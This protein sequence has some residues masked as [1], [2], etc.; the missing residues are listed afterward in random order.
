MFIKSERSS[1]LRARIW[2]VVA[3]RLQ[4]QHSSFRLRTLSN[5]PS[6]S[7][8]DAHE[9]FANSNE[10]MHLPSCNFYLKKC[11]DELVQFKT[12]LQ[13]RRTH[14]LVRTNLRLSFTHKEFGRGHNH[15]NDHVQKWKD[16]KV[17]EKVVTW[18][19][20]HQEW[21]WLEEKSQWS[22]VINET[23]EIILDMVKVFKWLT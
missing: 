14:Q 10:K 13:F 6:V 8:N 2:L 11:L 23:Y 20:D 19:P 21:L 9:S 22:I 1:S 4:T 18:Y 3:I 16:P 15:T 12:R 17:H 5:T 7:M